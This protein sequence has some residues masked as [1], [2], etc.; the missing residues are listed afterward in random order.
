MHTC[1]P[2]IGP[3]QRRRRLVSGFLSLAAA[4]ALAAAL[5]VATAPLLLRATLFLPLYGAA[6]GFLQYRERT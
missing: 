4:V 5:A 3:R 1:I 2:N 6:L